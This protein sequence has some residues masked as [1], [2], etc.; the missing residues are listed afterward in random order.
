M[1][2][3]SFLFISGLVLIY[4]LK[5]SCKNLSFRFYWEKICLIHYLHF[6]PW[7]ACTFSSLK[8]F[9]VENLETTP[10]IFLSKFSSEI[11]L[12]RTIN[13]WG[14][15]LTLYRRAFS[16]LCFLFLSVFFLRDT[17]DSQDYREGRGSP[18]FS[19]FPIPPAHEHSF[20]SSRFLPLLFNRSIC[21]YQTDSWWDLFS[22]EISFAFYLHF[23]WY[24]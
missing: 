9:S 2:G 7:K 14:S 20:S 3:F 23:H 17:N 16:V 1:Q 18:Y 24:N 8:Y 10:S 15:I 22:L 5:V 13:Y 11:Y 21:N 19:C 12:S 6:S 4:I